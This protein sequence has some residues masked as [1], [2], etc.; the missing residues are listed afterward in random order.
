MSIWCPKRDSPEEFKKLVKKEYWP[1][2]LRK[3]AKP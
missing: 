2:E 3:E 1:K